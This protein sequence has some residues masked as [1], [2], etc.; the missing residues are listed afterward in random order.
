MAHIYSGVSTG[1][2][3]HSYTMIDDGDAPAAAGVTVP[4]E[5][6][7]DNIARLDAG[8]IVDTNF[9]RVV[10]I[11][12]NVDTT[13]WLWDNQ[14][15]LLAQVQLAAAPLQV[16][17]PHGC[18]PTEISVYYDPANGHAN[19]PGTPPTLKL[20]ELDITTGVATQIGATATDAAASGAA[21]EVPRR[22]IVAISGL[23]V[24]KVTKRYTALFTSEGGSDY[25]AALKVLGAYYAADS[26]T[27][28]DIG[29]A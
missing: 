28:R 26:G 5:G 14:G 17:W 18:E 1:A 23:V 13:V 20:Y 21:Y 3:V 8:V 6:F 10:P 11:I 12:V 2:C 9:R 22:L 7:A 4:Q 19:V 15:S 16:D 29:A 24:N 27:Q 25:I